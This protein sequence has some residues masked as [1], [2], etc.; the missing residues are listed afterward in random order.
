MSAAKQEYLNA[1]EAWVNARR[2]YKRA[3][4]S[5]ALEQATVGDMGSAG[6]R[7]LDFHFNY[8]YSMYKPA[9]LRYLQALDTYARQVRPELKARLM[10][11]Y[12][13]EAALAQMVGQD[14]VA[15]RHL[16]SVEQLAVESVKVAHAE[17]V[18]TG[19]KETFAAVFVALSDAQ[20]MNAD[21]DPEVKAIAEEVF[22]LYERG[23][24]RREPGVVYVRQTPKVPRVTRPRPGPALW[25][26]RTI[27]Y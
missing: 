19:N 9:A 12:L 5:L 1:R 11:D 15:D 26:K 3:L 14:S 6:E 27:E 2:N 13:Q 23:K 18:R 4:N 17:W 8:A 24:V 10:Y 16:Q 20:F 22:D 7:G 25:I 21:H